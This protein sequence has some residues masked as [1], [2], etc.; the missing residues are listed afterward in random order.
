LSYDVVGRLIDDKAAT[1]GGWELVR[2]D[3]A[4]GYRT[5]MTSGEGR[6]SRFTLL[7]DATGQ[8]TYLDQ[9]P[10]GT[11]TE[12]TYTDGVNTVTRP[13]GSRV[14]SEQAPDPR[15]GMSVA[16]TKERS[17]NTPS[18]MALQQTTERT[19]ALDDP[20]DPL[21]HTALT[22]TVT[23]N[24]RS[25]SVAYDAATRTWST[26]SAAGR[27]GSVQLSAQGRPSLTQFGSLADVS[28]GYDSRGRL[29]TVNVGEGAEQ[30][31][32]AFSYDA[33]GNLASVS[34]D[35]ERTV[36][37]DYDLAGRVTR[38]ILPDDREIEYSYDPLGNLVAILPPGRNAHVFAYNEAE[39]EAGYSPPSLTGRIRSP[40]T[41]TTWISNSPGSTDRMGLR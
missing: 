35:L 34:D 6:V 39:L 24:G 8:R 29:S 27:N 15:F 22:E 1:G 14:V 13:D 25:Q 41:R 33:Y 3:L 10:D 21:S 18:G 37:Y 5:D 30:R 9:A 31:T 38:Q 23:V 19:A 20:F 17:V 11:V 26:T 12:R 7:R 32:T 36:H 4:D 2:T 28:Y 40:P 16:Y